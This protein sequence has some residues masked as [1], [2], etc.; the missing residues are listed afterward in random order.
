MVHAAHREHVCD[1]L[2]MASHDGRVVRPTSAVQR[3]KYMHVCRMGWNT[4]C[5][6][7]LVVE[8]MLCAQLLLTNAVINVDEDFPECCK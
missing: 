5:M 4:L 3:W 8:C 7:L 1:N 6:P 2:I